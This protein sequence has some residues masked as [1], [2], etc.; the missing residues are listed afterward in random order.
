MNVFN[1][2]RLLAGCCFCIL[3]SASGAQITDWQKPEPFRGSPS[4]DDPSAG[5]KED[6]YELPPVAIATNWIEFYVGVETRNRYFIARD[7][8]SV[9]KDEVTR[10]V[11]RVLTAGGVENISVEALRCATGDRRAYAYLRTGAQWVRSRDV[12]WS[13][14]ASGNRFNAH[15]H[16]LY[17]GLLCS[18]DR[19]MQP[20][21]SIEALAGSFA[22]RAGTPLTGYR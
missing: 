15:G 19:P 13:S 14:V 20:R 1:A 11:L 21:D 4:S 3:C 6:D 2:V 17:E 9:G 22:P 10:Y 18:A 12:R 5:L 7:S 16:V 8:L